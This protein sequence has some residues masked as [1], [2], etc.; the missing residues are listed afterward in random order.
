[1]RIFKT[2][3][4]CRGFSSHYL[5]FGAKSLKD[6]FKTKICN[7]SMYFSVSK[8]FLE[9]NEKNEINE[10]G[11][12]FE[13]EKQT[14]KYK[15]FINY[16]QNIFLIFYFQEI[17]TSYPDLSIIDNS[18]EPRLVFWHDF[19]NYIQKRNNVYINN[20]CIPIDQESYIPI[21]K[22]TE[23]TS[24]VSSIDE[25]LKEHFRPFPEMMSIL[26]SLYR[27]RKPEIYY[28]TGEKY[29]DIYE[30]FTFLKEEEE[31]VQDIGYIILA[32]N[33]DVDKYIRK[34]IGE[35]RVQRYSVPEDGSCLFH[36]LARHLSNTNEKNLRKEIVKYER[37]Y[38][39]DLIAPFLDIKFDE[40]LKEMTKT[41]TFGGEPEI[42]AFCNLYKLRVAIYDVE[43]KNTLLYGNSKKTIFLLF[44]KTNEH[45]E[46][47]DIKN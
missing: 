32:P 34:A 15:I 14:D 11:I 13:L 26:N 27:K 2:L 33:I 22:A 43:R 29:E 1:M 3:D 30:Y 45:Y 31:C 10:Q 41:I 6:I 25:D 5:S 38:M 28:Y 35:N 37:E 8:D 20:N 46:I 19:E 7:N 12:R 40:Y 47:L 17:L 42:I 24:D 18:Y 23:Q 16:C 21:G 44:H 9:K 39:K 4:N 36:S